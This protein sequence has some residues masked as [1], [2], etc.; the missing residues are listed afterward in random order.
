MRSHAVTQIIIWIL[1]FD[2]RNPNAHRIF[3]FGPSVQEIEREFNSFT[4]KPRY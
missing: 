1:M 4:E 2:S 3:N